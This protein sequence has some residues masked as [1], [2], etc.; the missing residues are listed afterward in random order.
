MTSTG[1]I[2]VVIGYKTTEQRE[3]DEVLYGW[4]QLHIYSP[5][6]QQLQK[7]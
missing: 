5:G 7:G 3:V 4:K 1:D 6:P 2:I